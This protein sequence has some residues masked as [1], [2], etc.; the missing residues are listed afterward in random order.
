MAFFLH[1]GQKKII[2]SFPNGM[3]LVFSLTNTFDENI[4]KT[5][6]CIVYMAQKAGTFKTAS[7]H[8]WFFSTVFV[9]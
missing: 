5:N 8:C 1:F 9:S 7:L 6:I 4:F 2:V 3:C